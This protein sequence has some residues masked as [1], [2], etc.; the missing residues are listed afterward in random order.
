MQRD[1]FR[2]IDRLREISEI[3]LSEATLREVQ[4][5]ANF[6]IN[7]PESHQATNANHAYFQDIKTSMTSKAVQDEVKEA[8]KESKIKRS[9]SS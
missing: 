1:I 2:L 9:Y 4:R 5:F 6:I 3:P 8:L 7:T